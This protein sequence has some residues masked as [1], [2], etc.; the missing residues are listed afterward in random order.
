MP[1]VAL[2]VQ[3]VME[4]YTDAKSAEYIIKHGRAILEG[5]AIANKCRDY[6][7]GAGKVCKSELKLASSTEFPEDNIPQSAPFQEPR[8]TD[9]G[10]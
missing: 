7:T 2:G 8:S 1:S 5:G 3:L 10:E 6:G 9:N 4:V